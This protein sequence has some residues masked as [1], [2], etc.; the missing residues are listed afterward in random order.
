MCLQQTSNSF[1]FGI[2]RDGKYIS[3]ANL[4]T[5]EQ[6]LY[7]LAF[8]CAILEYSNTPLRVILLDDMLDHLDSSNITNAFEAMKSIPGVQFICAGVINCTVKDTFVIT[9]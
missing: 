7:M 5:G 4:S 1:S 9:I 6:C 2:S 3:Y 8:A